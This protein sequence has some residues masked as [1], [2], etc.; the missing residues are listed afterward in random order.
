M[1]ACLVLPFVPIVGPLAWSIS[2]V[3]LAIVAHNEVIRGPARF[4]SDVLGRGWGR[5]FRFFLDEVVLGLMI[6][7]VYFV[8][9]LL[10]VAVGSAVDLKEHPFVVLLA[11]I[12]FFALMGFVVVASIRLSL[13]FPSRAIG[14][15]LRWRE[16]WAVARGHSGGLFIASFLVGLPVFVL[17]GLA[18]LISLGSLVVQ[19][20][21]LGLAMPIQILIHSSFLALAYQHCMMDFERRQQGLRTAI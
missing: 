1:L 10:L 12:P 13:R 19:W 3:P 7:S 2:I 9:I 8:P 18:T 20:V 11:L 15:V 21:F 16:A 5:V 4:N 14:R 6:L 17:W